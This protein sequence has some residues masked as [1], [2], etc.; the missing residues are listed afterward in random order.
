MKKTNEKKTLKRLNKITSDRNE[1]RGKRKIISK[2]K[3]NSWVAF[4]LSGGGKPAVVIGCSSFT[5]P[6]VTTKR[7]SRTQGYKRA[8]EMYERMM[9]LEFVDKDRLQRK[10]ATITLKTAAYSVLAHRS[11]LLLPGT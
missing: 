1:G 3:R 4:I 11:L 8:R 5:N 7:A 9:E 2:R 6:C 10:A